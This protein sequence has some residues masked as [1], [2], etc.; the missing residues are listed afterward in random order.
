MSKKKKDKKK[1]VNDLQELESLDLNESTENQNLDALSADTSESEDPLSLLVEES[2]DIFLSSSDEADTDELQIEVKSNSNSDVEAEAQTEAESSIV[3]E[4]IFNFENPKIEPN[5]ENEFDLLSEGLESDAELN[6]QSTDEESVD[7]LDL[8]SSLEDGASK[9]DDNADGNADSLDFLSE[10]LIAEPTEPM[11]QL[12]DNEAISIIE[13]LLFISDRPVGLTTFKNAFENTNINTKKI[14]E[15]LN[16]LKI[17][18]VNARRGISLEEIDG[19]YQLRTKSDNQ[20][21][22]KKIL[23]PKVFKL[24][25]PSLETLSIIAYK[26]PCVKSQV[27]EV[28]GVESGHLVR[29]LM[30]K[31]LVAFDGKSDFPGRPML[32]KTTR[33]FLEIF[34]LRN[35]SELPSLAD[36]EE[37][38]TDGIGDEDEKETL[39]Q[40]AGKLEESFEA[41]SYSIG[42]EELGKITEQLSGISTQTEFFE[43]EKRKQRESRDRDRAEGIREALIL[44]DAV[45]PKDEKW[46]QRYEIKLHQEASDQPDAGLTADEKVDLELELES[47]VELTFTEEDSDL[48]TLSLDDDVSSEDADSGKD[49]PA[50]E[51]NDLADLIEEDP[52]DLL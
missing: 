28:R 6:V 8:L 10:G 9:A 44:G 32:Y 14:K 23:K 40:L 42:E 26:Q 2:L 47:K 34:G 31:G 35:L 52:L 17:D 39:S 46:L 33:K 37:I 36:M 13:S 41:Q 18:F 19:A 5:S 51:K 48:E 11:A 12:V 22:I 21:F 49:S 43:V 38:L 29:A 24:T 30:D 4:I 20:D 16:E 3:D 7:G 15:L 27:D 45:D 1:S 50:K 25:G